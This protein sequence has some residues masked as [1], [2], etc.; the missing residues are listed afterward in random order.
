MAEDRHLSPEDLAE[1]ENVPVSTVYSWNYM[2]TGPTY[3]RAGR[4]VRYRL[5]DVIKWEKAQEVPARAR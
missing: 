4:H 5:S 2:G 3:F 1:R